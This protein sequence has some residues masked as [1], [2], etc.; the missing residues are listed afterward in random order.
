MARFSIIWD[1]STVR[2]WRAAR[3]GAQ[4]LQEFTAADVD[5]LLATLEAQV[6]TLKITHLRLYLDLPELDHHVE[7]VPKLAPKLRRKL[8][9]QRQLKMY[10]NEPRVWV[11]AD[12]DLDAEG[13]Q[14]FY[15]ISS[16][17]HQIS[18]TI[19][20]WARSNGILL[21]GI[22]SLPQ[23]LAQLDAPETQNATNAPEQGALI[24]FLAIGSAGYLI[25]RNPT[26][27]PLFFSRI[28]SATPDPANLEAGARR[29][30]LFVEQEFSLTPQLQ[31]DT[32][33]ESDDAVILTALNKRKVI[34]QQNLVLPAEKRRQN[35][36]HFRHRA[37]A[38]LTVTLIVVLYLTLPLIE[39]RKALEL[40]IGD[41]ATE[42][43]VK[44]NAVNK[45]QQSL[46][47]SSVYVDVIEFSEGRETGDGDAAVPTPILV[48]M[49]AVSNALPALVELD[50]YEVQIDSDERKAILTLIGRPLSADLDLKAAINAM[51]DGLK[52]RSW[53]MEA[54]EL[55]FEQESRSSRFANQRG[56]LRKF[57]LR[58]T[59]SARD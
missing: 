57:T 6:A 47:A 4:L 36:Q 48:I 53:L 29:L 13:A 12:M 54:P 59:L 20:R 1:Q 45:L 35:L 27:R 58:L 33:P 55:S 40:D 19:T 23:A 10:G 11:A 50:S 14:Q 39:K 18:S 46:D 51:T 28:D 9:Q 3:G 24:H 26:G 41:K 56:V 34:P 52:K 49:H 5:A 8:L 2:V 44:Q 16:L 31:I 32:E 17:P 30:I 22:F 7:R 25:A 38:L 21:E 42:L 15:L 43:Q 37:F